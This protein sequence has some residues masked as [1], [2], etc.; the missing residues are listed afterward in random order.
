MAFKNPWISL[1]LKKKNQIKNVLVALC[2]ILYSY[3]SLLHSYQ[4]LVIRY[5]Q[6]MEDNSIYCYNPPPPLR[7][8]DNGF[9][10]TLSLI[11]N[12]IL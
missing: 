7:K 10:Y 11:D 8:L 1:F 3:T 5:E 12:S 4:L 2:Y 6:A 9:H